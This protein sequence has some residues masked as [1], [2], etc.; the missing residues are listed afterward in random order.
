MTA[1]V[2]YRPGFVRVARSYVCIS[3]HVRCAACIAAR[4]RRHLDS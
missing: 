2:R 1:S 4:K 3:G